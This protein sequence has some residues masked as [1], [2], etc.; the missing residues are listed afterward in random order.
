MLAI[1]SPYKRF[2][3]LSLLNSQLSNLNLKSKYLVRTKPR[4]TMMTRQ[5]ML[6]WVTIRETTNRK[7]ESREEIVIKLSYLTSA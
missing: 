5:A 3:E 1:D 4:C 6:D 7:T 2:W